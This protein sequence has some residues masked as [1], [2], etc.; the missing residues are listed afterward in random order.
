MLIFC[1]LVNVI[2]TNK[3]LNLLVGA[4]SSTSHYGLT[5]KVELK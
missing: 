2:F 3:T 5:E 1:V 4:K